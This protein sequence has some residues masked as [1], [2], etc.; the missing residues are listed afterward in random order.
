MSTDFQ[1]S[2]SYWVGSS[3]AVLGGLG[4]LIVCS[5]LSQLQESVDYHLSFNNSC[6]LLIYLVLNKIFCL[7][8]NTNLGFK[9]HIYTVSPEDIFY[10]PTN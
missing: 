1:T 7:F 2:N 6:K 10:W 9:Y 5:S 4:A 8:G 3:L